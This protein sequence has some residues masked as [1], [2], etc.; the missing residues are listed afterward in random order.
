MKYVRILLFFFAFCSPVA[1]QWQVPQYSVPTGRGGGG[2]GFDSTG[3][4]AAG[5]VLSGN[6][7]AKPSFNPLAAALNTDCGVAPTLC[8]KVFGYV[9]VAWYGAVCDSSTNDAA[10]I[11]A[12]WNAAA[13]ANVD[14][15]LVSGPGA[16]SVS[17][18]IGSSTLVMPAPVNQGGGSGFSKSSMLR[19]SGAGLVRLLSTDAG[20]GTTCAIS[21]SGTYGVNSS[22][23]G[24]MGGFTLFN[25]NT[26]QTG[27]GLCL[28]NVTSIN[29]DD[30]AIQYFGSGILATDCISV[31]MTRMWF[32]LNGNGV[33]AQYV[34]N[35]PANAWNVTYSN[36]DSQLQYAIAVTGGTVSGG[37]SG[38]KVF[39]IDHDTFQ[40]NGSAGGAGSIYN[41]IDCSIYGGVG[42]NITN[43][44]FE[45]DIGEE[46]EFDAGGA[47]NTQCVH[48]VKNN[49][50]VRSLSG[51]TAAVSIANSGSGTYH[52]TVNLEGN[53]FSDVLLTGG[54]FQ[55]LNFV[56]PSVFNATYICDGNR[57]NVPA[58]INSRCGNVG[59]N[60][61]KSSDANAQY[62]GFN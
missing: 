4:G 24:V 37:T 61:T 38:A 13:V 51:L 6:G 60:Q 57:V 44:Y 55:W 43:N 47:A 48:N 56:T 7:A 5:T 21:I 52:T 46:I 35:S 31:N 3:P 58:E 40:S 29:L 34:T 2:T 8:T 9:N 30:I 41:D 45:G 42:M 49:Y 32:E 22:L 17:C 27:R 53:Y 54:S 26:N 62:V 28:T 23:G 18:N 59:A 15:W 33:R 19:G 10:A 36:F 39:N 14:A 12:A 16:S 11:Q 50:F 20:S 25:Q 1:A